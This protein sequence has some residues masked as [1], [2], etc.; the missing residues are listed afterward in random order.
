MISHSCCWASRKYASK[1]LAGT[2]AMRCARCEILRS[3]T[4][5]SDRLGKVFWSG[6]LLGAG[7]RQLR[8]THRNRKFESTSLQQ[9]V[10]KLY[11]GRRIAFTRDQKQFRDPGLTLPDQNFDRIGTIWGHLPPPH[12]TAN[13]VLP[14]SAGTA[15]SSLTPRSRYEGEAPRGSGVAPSGRFS[16]ARV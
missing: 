4:P 16:R 10:H 2:A 5:N 3:V 1:S 7:S 9:R 13:R 11:A 14:N 12:I 6:T 15:S 8:L